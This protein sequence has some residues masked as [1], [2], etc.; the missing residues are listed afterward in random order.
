M[1][2]CGKVLSETA[3]EKVIVS[4]STFEQVSE[5]ADKNAGQKQHWTELWPTKNQSHK[6]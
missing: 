2:A 3:L 1:D 5:S 4:Q 6:H